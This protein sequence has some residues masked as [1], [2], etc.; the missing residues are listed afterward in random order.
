MSRHARIKYQHNTVI[1]LDSQ[2]M[3]MAEIDRRKA[4]KAVVAGRAVFL[5]SFRTYETSAT[6]SSGQ[7][8]KAIIYHPRAER[9]VRPRFVGGVKGTRAILRR[10]RFRC[11]YCGCKLRASTGT[12]DHVIPECQGGQTTWSN[13]VAACLSCNQRKGGRTPEQ[14][15]M[16]LLWRPSSP[17]AA[18]MARLEKM[19]ADELAA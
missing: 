9:K 7:M 6:V 10:D 5:T 13:L 18:L 17:I 12:K 19:I 8:M 2:F 15:G 3:P 14:A 4:I 11:A 16:A 1:A